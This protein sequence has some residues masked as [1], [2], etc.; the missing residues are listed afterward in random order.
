MTQVKR[1][2]VTEANQEINETATSTMPARRKSRR[3]E[4]EVVIRGTPVCRQISNLRVW[5]LAG[6]PGYCSRR[7]SEDFILSVHGSFRNG[8][9][10]IRNLFG[11]IVILKYKKLK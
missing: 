4:E 9:Y 6:R 2:C 1:V 3:T 5:A 11:G 7:V 10:S 8:R